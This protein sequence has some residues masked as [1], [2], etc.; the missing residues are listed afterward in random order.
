MALVFTTIISFV[1]T[2]AYSCSN[3]INHS[4]SDLDSITSDDTTSKT[5]FIVSGVDYFGTVCR[6]K[7]NMTV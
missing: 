1:Y 5:Y 2:N 7:R 4:D 6:I 3:V